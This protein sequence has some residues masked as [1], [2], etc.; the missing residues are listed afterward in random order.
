MRSIATFSI[1]TMSLILAMPA[2]ADLIYDNGAPDNEGHWLSDIDTGYFAHDTFRLEAGAET[3][4]DIHWAG[5]YGGAG[6]LGI[7][8][9]EIIITGDHGGEPIDAVFSAYYP[10]DVH[11][12][13]TG[14]II[15]ATY[16]GYAYWVDIAPLTLTAE[17]TYWIS[18]RNDA[19]DAAGSWE[20]LT[21]STFGGDAV[22]FNPQSGG[23]VARE[24]NMSFSL[25][26]DAIS[27][28]VPEPASMTLL[29]L[30]LAGLAWRKRKQHV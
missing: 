4:T 12:T 2:S 5:I 30:G 16:D 10:T 19:C 8:Q 25:T 9:F 23:F 1:V 26:D 18:I 3:I 15:D 24:S 17:T 14:N 28:P 6:P 22:Q 7:D 13:A 27:P 20:W 29:G 11:R 21:S